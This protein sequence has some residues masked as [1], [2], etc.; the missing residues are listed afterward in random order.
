MISVG[1]LAERN[2][3][4]KIDGI[5]VRTPGEIREVHVA[6]A[7][8]VPLDRC[9]SIEIMRHRNGSTDQVLYLICKSGAVH[10]A[11]LANANLK[12]NTRSFIV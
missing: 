8:N 3:K 9:D 6:M 7:R 1:R 10:S 12:S 5:D 4:V 2:K 11:G